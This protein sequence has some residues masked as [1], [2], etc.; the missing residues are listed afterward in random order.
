LIVL[1]PPLLPDAEL[2]VEDDDGAGALDE[3][4]LL[5]EP[6]HA[7]SPTVRAT[8]TRGRAE[9]LDTCVPLVRDP[10]PA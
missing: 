7:A 3:V 9:I 8:A 6:P 2:D 5:L 10:D 1:P 4:L